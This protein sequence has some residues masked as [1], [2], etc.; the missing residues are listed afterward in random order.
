M[1]IWNE[2]CPD[3]ETDNENEKPDMPQ[4]SHNDAEKH[5]ILSKWLMRF[6]M[7]LQVKFF[8]P[9]KAWII[10]LSFIHIFMHSRNVFIICKNACARN[11]TNTVYYAF[12][13]L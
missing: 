13:V 7:I 1:E 8:L 4:F 2:S 5:V 6:L 12:E 3:S 10:C 9:D 11:S